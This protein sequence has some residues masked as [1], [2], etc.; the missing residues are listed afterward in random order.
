MIKFLNMVSLNNIAWFNDM[1]KLG[2]LDMTPSYQR[3][4]V[5]TVKQK[6]YLIDSVLNGYP[7]PEIYIQEDISQNGETRYIIVDG[8][9]RMRSILEFLDDQFP[10]NKEESPEFNGAFFKDLTIEQKKDFFAYNFVVRKLPELPESEIRQIFRRLN[11]NVVAL[12]KQELRKAVYSGPFIKL[13]T[14]LSDD[15]FWIAMKLFTPNDIKRMR[16]VEYI[17]ELALSVVE[18]VQNK[19]DRLEKYYEE[20][21]VYFPDEMKIRVAFAAI[22]KQLLSIADNLSKTRWKNKTDFYTLFNALLPYVEILPL[23]EIKTDELK[24]LLIR[25]S[26]M[27]TEFLSMET[28]DTDAVPEFIKNYAKGIRAATD[29]SARTLRQKALDQYLAPLLSGGVQM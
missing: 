27:V 12:N 11:R 5:W 3:N 17:S 14:L 2:R 8:Q 29:I 20:T 7:I 25:F 15:M 13:M 10:L 1:N 16:D 22:M 18:G 24:I 19:K 21:E 23:D 26:D 9:Q 4:P 28:D 6:S